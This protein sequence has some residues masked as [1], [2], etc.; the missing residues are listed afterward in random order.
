MA[1][2]LTRRFPT[3]LDFIKS[4]RTGK[5]HPENHFHAHFYRTLLRSATIR[6]FMVGYELLASTQRAITPESAGD[7][8]RKFVS[9]YE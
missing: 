2:F 9:I 5:K 7:M 1:N 8:L 6:K 3:L 4:L